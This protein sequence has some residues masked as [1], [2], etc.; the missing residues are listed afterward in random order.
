MSN[1]D[2]LKRRAENREK[3]LAK[4][5]KEFQTLD[6]A[7][8]H[9]FGS[10]VNG[11]KDEFSDID[12]WVTIDDGKLKNTLNHLTSIYKS[13]APIL[14]K[15]NSK[16]WSPVG[17]RASSIIHEFNG[18][19]FVVDYYISKLSETI[20]PYNAKRLFGVDS[21][22]KG[23]WRLNQHVYPKMKD[24]HTLRKDVDLLLD[25]IFI[26][27]KGIIRQWQ[28]DDFIN[29]IKKLHQNIRQN[30]KVELTARHISLNI[31]SNDRLLNDLC[32]IANQRQK[33]VVDKIREFGR[34]VE[35]R[36]I[37]D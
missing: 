34:L 2:F 25:L 13:I 30:Y 15:H 27:Y 29:T 28:D 12:I 24:T 17:G 4:I 35:S 14:L 19:L 10:G 26:S 31:K 9:L 7:T 1:S 32:Q 6:P 16:T 21:I 11:F 22:T 23:E 37:C 8:I 3:L 18:D 5:V 36:N 33:K 20:L